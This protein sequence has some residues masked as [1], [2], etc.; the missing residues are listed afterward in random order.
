MKEGF[1]TMKGEGEDRRYALLITAN[2]TLPLMLDR[3]GPHSRLIC[4][5]PNLEHLTSLRAPFPF[6][7][8]LHPD[9]PAL[10]LRTSPHQILLPADKP[11]S[12]RQAVTTNPHS[13][14]D[15][16][17]VVWLRDP[18]DLASATV[19]DPR[20]AQIDTAYLGQAPTPGLL[21]DLVRVGAKQDA[22]SKALSAATRSC[23]AHDTPSSAF[24]ELFASFSPGAEG[25]EG[26]DPLLATAFKL[27]QRHLLK[28]LGD[29]L[30][31]ARERLMLSD[32]DMFVCLT[33]AGGSSPSPLSFALHSHAPDALAD[34]GELVLTLWE[35]KAL[36]S[37]T[38][39]E[40]LRDGIGGDLSDGAIQGLKTLVDRFVQAGALTRE[41]ADSLRPQAAIGPKVRAKNRF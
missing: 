5:D 27:N 23:S 24:L 38:L 6:E 15:H 19:D 41:Q 37:D 16:V 29:A 34:F 11:S 22:L 10:Y 33:A 32:G 20:D 28:P 40:V 1:K 17:M 13:Q 39:G 4:A 7:R 31:R 3:S 8:L 14:A 21:H 35:K 12:Q 36:S 9:D 26:H 2:H 18:L 30:A 25:Y